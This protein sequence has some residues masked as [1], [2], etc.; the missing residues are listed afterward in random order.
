[1]CHE[2]VRHPEMRV[3]GSILGFSPFIDRD[4]KGELRTMVMAFSDTELHEGFV[5]SFPEQMSHQRDKVL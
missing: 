4:P 2:V 1:V 5:S 3:C